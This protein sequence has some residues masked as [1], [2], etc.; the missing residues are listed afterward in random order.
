MGQLSNGEKNIKYLSLKGIR[1]N[2]VLSRYFPAFIFYIHIGHSAMF[3]Y[4]NMPYFTYGVLI[5]TV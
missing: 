4:P 1:F 5:N 3:F 2:P